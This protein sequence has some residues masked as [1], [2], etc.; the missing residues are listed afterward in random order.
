MDLVATM[1]IYTVFYCS[2]SFASNTV[3]GTQLWH[4]QGKFN[5]RKGYKVDVSRIYRE[6]GR[7]FIII[8]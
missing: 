5:D 7:R 3:S 6:T 4:N 2:E 8:L 1:V